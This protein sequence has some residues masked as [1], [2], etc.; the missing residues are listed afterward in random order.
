MRNQRGLRSLPAV[1]SSPAREDV[2]W[3]GPDLFRFRSASSGRTMRWRFVDP[4]RG[5]MVK[6]AGRRRSADAVGPRTDISFFGAL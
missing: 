1:S 5:C 6:S 2:D 3:L 4:D